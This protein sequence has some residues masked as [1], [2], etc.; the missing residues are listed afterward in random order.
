MDRQPFGGQPGVGGADGS[1]G[2]HAGSWSGW[3]GVPG[4]GQAEGGP[5]DLHGCRTLHHQQVGGS[6]TRYIVTRKWVCL[7]LTTPSTGGWVCHTLHNH[8]QVGE[9]A[10]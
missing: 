5:P 3:T 10:A 6:A 7:P 8:H 9:S 2:G 4:D 1:P